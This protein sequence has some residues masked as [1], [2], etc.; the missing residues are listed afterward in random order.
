VKQPVSTSTTTAD[1]SFESWSVRSTSN[2]LYTL[3]HSLSPT[4]H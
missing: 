2:S 3:L 4:I 1:A